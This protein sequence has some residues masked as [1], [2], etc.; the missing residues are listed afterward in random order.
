M[1][2]ALAIQRTGSTVAL[3]VL[4]GAFGCAPVLIRGDYMP[5]G[6]VIADGGLRGQP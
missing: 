2:F 3:F 5:E 4:G 6:I 1:Q